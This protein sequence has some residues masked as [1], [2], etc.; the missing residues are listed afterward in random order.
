MTAV[1]GRRVPDSR[2][3]AAGPSPVPD[4]WSRPRSYSEERV[5][6]ENSRLRAWGG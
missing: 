1:P 4:L 2:G 5:F 6:S 3:S